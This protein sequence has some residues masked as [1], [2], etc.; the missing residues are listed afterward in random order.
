[1]ELTLLTTL[2]YTVVLTTSLFT[3]LLSLLKSTGSVFDLSISNSSTS[4]FKLAKPVFLV[5]S[6]VSTPVAFLNLPMLHN[7]INLIQLSHFLLKVSV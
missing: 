6:D 4:G 2:S 7:Y 1:M 3:T 5:K